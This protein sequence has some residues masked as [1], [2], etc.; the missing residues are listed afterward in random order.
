MKGHENIP[1]RLPKWD[2]KYPCPIEVTLYIS[3]LAVNRMSRGFRIPPEPN[4]PKIFNEYRESRG[5]A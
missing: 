1:S 2:E 5:K 4:W 3:A